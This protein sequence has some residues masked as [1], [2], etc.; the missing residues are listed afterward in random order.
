M[1][2]INQKISEYGELYKQRGD[3]PDIKDIINTDAPKDALLRFLSR[4]NPGNLKYFGPNT[5]WRWS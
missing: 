3:L 1:R 4:F 2:A 5:E